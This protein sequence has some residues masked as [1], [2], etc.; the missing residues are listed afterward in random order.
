MGF[1]HGVGGINAAAKQLD[2]I[3]NNVA[4][5]GTIGFKGSRAEFADMYA[6]NFYGVAAT[7][8]GLGTRTETIAQQFSQG[9]INTTGNQMDM[10]ISGN[11]F[12]VMNDPNGIS[13]SRN[14]QFKIDRQGF[15][16]NNG[17]SNLQG[18]AVDPVTGKIL[19]GSRTDLKVDNTLLA[20]RPTD[21]PGGTNASPVKFELNVDSRATPVGVRS[22]RLDTAAPPV[23]YV[24]ISTGT[25]VDVS[26]GQL[27]TISAAG[28]FAP[29]AGAFYTA[30]FSY[31][32]GAGVSHRYTPSATLP[33]GSTA[34]TSAPDPAATVLP[35]DPSNPN[36]YTHTT[37]TKIYDSL[38]NPYTMNIYLVKKDMTGISPSVTSPW[39]VNVNVL[40]PTTGLP[41]TT[42]LTNPQTVTFD[43]KGMITGAS[44]LTFGTF[45]PSA[46]PPAVA[47]DPI[48][49]SVDLVGTTQQGASFAV[50]KI[51]QEGY[52]PSVVTNLE[53]SKEGIIS[54][55]YSNGQNKAI[56]QVILANFPNQQGLQPIGNNRWI[57]TYQSGTPAYN[58]PGST[59][60]GLIQAQAL[61]DANIDLT[62]ELVNMITAQ[63]FY[64]ANAQTIKVQ[65]AVLQS[66]IN[67]R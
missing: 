40:D 11:G 5:A 57:Q 53:V 59:N 44:E 35:F 56:G 25:Y 28:A 45:T 41:I 47:A 32:N 50:N 3:G 37:S 46:V 1:Q 43:S 51:I 29:T 49:I 67:L 9:N 36:T 6:A 2:V 23:R 39:E 26:N 54:A 20:G 66:V 17:G 42:G 48:Q 34:G 31:D 7:Q 63:R 19:E 10:A 21:F 4:N 33:L 52:A 12:F 65:D 8:T 62:A 16:V 38:G 60:T 58:N 27:G 13:Y 30:S 24:E 55:R 61:E 18:W 22:S 64:Q 15:I 14:G